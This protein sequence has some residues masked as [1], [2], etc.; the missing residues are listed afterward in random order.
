MAGTTYKQQ[1]VKFALERYRDELVRDSEDRFPRLQSLQDAYTAGATPRQI[2]R[3]RA[4]V[5]GR[6]DVPHDCPLCRLLAGSHEEK[7]SKA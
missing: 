5:A 3:V 1:Q 6:P 7:G 4:E 2:Q